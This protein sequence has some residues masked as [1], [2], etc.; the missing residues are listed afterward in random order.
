MPAPPTFTAWKCCLHHG[1]HVLQRA[2]PIGLDGSLDGG[3]DSAPGGWALG[4]WILQ[5]CS[6]DRGIQQGRHA[7]HTVALLPL[8]DHSCDGM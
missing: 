4:G 8:V 1:F 3:M 5:G 6:G 7:L 2:F